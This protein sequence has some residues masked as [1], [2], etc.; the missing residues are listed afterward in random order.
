M[1]LALSSLPSLPCVRNPFCF[2][3][4]CVKVFS[5][6]QL[7]LHYSHTSTWTLLGMWTH[8]TYKFTSKFTFFIIINNLY[9]LAPWVWSSFYHCQVM[10]NQFWNW[11]ETIL[12]YTVALCVSITYLAYANVWFQQHKKQPLSDW[13][14]LEYVERYFFPIWFHFPTLGRKNYIYAEKCLT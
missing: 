2:V 12:M 10:M 6:Q 8:F 3:Q 11:V 9:Y 4:P 5:S 1:W 7:T 14:F 13:W